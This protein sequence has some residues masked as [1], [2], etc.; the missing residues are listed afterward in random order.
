MWGIGGGWELRRYVL[1]GEKVVVEEE[2]E[3][4]VIEEVI[5]EDH[6]WW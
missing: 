3:E 6:R 5:G 2:D 4:E 1:E